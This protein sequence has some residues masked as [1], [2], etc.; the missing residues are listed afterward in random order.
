MQ[1][2]KNDLKDELRKERSRN[3]SMYFSRAVQ[4]QANCLDNYKDKEEE[5]NR[6]DCV[7]HL[8]RRL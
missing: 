8:R 5:R 4:K 6:G 7:G 1:K 3:L 2:Q